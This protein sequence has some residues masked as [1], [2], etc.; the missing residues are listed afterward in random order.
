MWHHEHMAERW[1]LRKSTFTVT[2]VC[3]RKCFRPPHST[4]CLFIL[5][6]V[7][8]KRMWNLERVWGKRFDVRG[9]MHFLCRSWG[10]H[11]HIALEFKRTHSVPAPRQ[12][13]VFSTSYPR[14]LQ[15][16]LSRFLMWVERRGIHSTW[17]PRDEKKPKKGWWKETRKSTMDFFIFKWTDQSKAWCGIWKKDVIWHFSDKRVNTG[18][19][20]GWGCRLPGISYFFVLWGVSV[21]RGSAVKVLCGLLKTEQALFRT[22]YPAPVLVWQQGTHFSNFPDPPCET[23]CLK[24]TVVIV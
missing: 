12:T 10:F 8:W 6:P 17:K 15:Q 23:P 20:A 1:L 18:Q 16:S 5:A 14:M 3:N 22:I 11:I 19:K 9:Q 24:S 2:A 21:K 7:M 4:H 13:Q